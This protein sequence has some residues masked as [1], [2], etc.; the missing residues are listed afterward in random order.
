MVIILFLACSGKNADSSDHAAIHYSGDELVERFN[1]ATCDLLI[2]PE[3]ID[4]LTD[5]HAPVNLFGN[6]ADCMNSQNL[7][8]TH[9]SN[10]PYL[11]E[12]NQQLAL[13]CI[14]ILETAICSESDLCINGINI[15]RH[16]ACSSLHD[17]VVNNCN[18]F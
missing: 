15:F 13:S 1:S 3:C 4:H 8:F 11:F 17:L 10:I 6:W 9:C 14:E 16:Q 12:Q 2:V 5:C 18:P 7:N